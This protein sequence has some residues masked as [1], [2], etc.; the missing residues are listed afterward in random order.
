M[1]A[2]ATAA[3]PVA[4]SLPAYAPKL[5][6]IVNLLIILVVGFFLF[7]VWAVRGLW[8]PLVRESTIDKM[9]LPSIRNVYC[10]AWLCSCACPCLF[11][12]FHPPF[13][14]R[15]VVHEAWNLRRIDV[16][17]AMECFV[18]VKCGLNPAKTTVIQAVPMNNRSQPVIWN[19]AVDLEVQI[20]DEVLGFEVYNSAQLTPDQLIGSVAVSVSDAYSRMQGHLDEVKSLERDSAKLMWMS[21]GSTIEDAGRITFSLY[22]TR[23]QTPLPP[24]LPGMDFGMHQDSATAA[25]LPMYAS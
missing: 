6:V 10:V 16:V 19:D 8:W 12:R 11:S 21:D 4:A 25:L 9:R 2:V 23:P 20:T 13:R 5:E 3:P 24:V 22:G 1:D 14:L 18:V 17:N 7:L 15:V